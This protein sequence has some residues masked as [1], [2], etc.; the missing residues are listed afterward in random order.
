MNKYCVAYNFDGY[1]EVIIEADSPEEA[2]EKYY[3]GDF[4]NEIEEG[5]NYE[6]T[7]VSKV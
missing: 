7:E 6:V 5:R 2:K 4:G 1:G 3:E